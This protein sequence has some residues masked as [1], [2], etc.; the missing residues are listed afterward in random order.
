MV[1]PTD[2]GPAACEGA[3]T[4]SEPDTTASEAAATTAAR[5]RET[6]R[7][8]IAVM[9]T[10]NVLVRREVRAVRSALTA[11]GALSVHASSHRCEHHAAV[12]NWTFNQPDADLWDLLPFHGAMSAGWPPPDRLCPAVQRLW[13][14]ASSIIDQVTSMLF[15]FPPA[16][17]A[18]PAGPSE[19]AVQ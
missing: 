12:L 1:R 13:K 5:R 17:H 14:V 7:C 11:S 15:L 10:P 6:R 8:C 9:T 4:S 2:A 3:A 16:P 19:A 18:P